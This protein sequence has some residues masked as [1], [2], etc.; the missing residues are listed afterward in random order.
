LRRWFVVLIGC[1]CALAVQGRGRLAGDPP[2]APKRSGLRIEYH[3]T[4]VLPGAGPDEKAATVLQRIT[5]DDTGTKLLYE[6]ISAG[7]G[8]G[9]APGKVGPAGAGGG[10]PSKKVIFRTDGPNPILYEVLDAKSYREHP[11]DLN[12][13]QKERRLTEENE[14]LAA[15]QLPAKE[16]AAFFRENPHLRSDGERNA[17]LAREAGEKTLGYECD[18]ILVT[19]NGR[20]IVQGLVTR[21]PVGSGGPFQLYRRLGAFSDEVLLELAKVEGI[22]LRGKIT[23]VTALRANELEVEATGIDRVDVSP[24]LFEVT[25]LTR[26]ED[27]PKEALCGFC[28][29]K[30]LDPKHPGGK[31]FYDGK[32]KLFCCEKCADEYRKKKLKGE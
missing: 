23:V 4:G 17:N 8:G 12:E 25:G 20:P 5:L 18:R 2:P 9:G 31:G 1:A 15:N 14:V 10:A 30:I 29:K 26:V 24:E 22:L 19:E 11:R 27:V 21:E 28:G 3:T 6:E 7:G 16:R 32:I 13:I